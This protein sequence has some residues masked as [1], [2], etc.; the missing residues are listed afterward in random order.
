M[1]ES[2][3]GL[4]KRPFLTVPTLERYCPVAGQ[5]AAFQSCSRAIS[6]SE[7]PV[8]ILGRTGLGKS[9]VCLRIGE[10]FRRS[11]EVILLSSSQLC[12]RRALL[13]NLLFELRMPYRDLSEG[14]LRLSLLDRLQPSNENPTDGVVLIVD[15][16]QT[17]SIK[18]LEEL[19]L[20]TNL[21]RDG[22][23]RVRLVLCGSMR[24]EE[25]LGHPQLESLNQRIACRSY[26]IPLSQSETLS[27]LT[28]KVELCGATIGS[29]FTDDAM[30][31][32]HRAT[33]GVPRLID[34]IADQS[35]CLASESRQRPISAS[36]IES[37]WAS[38]Q[39]LPLPWSDEGIP[40]EHHA[41][42][43]IEYGALNDDNDSEFA[44]EDSVATDS[45]EQSIANIDST[46]APTSAWVYQSETQERPIVSP[47]PSAG[48][49]LSRVIPSVSQSSIPEPSKSASDLWNAFINANEGRFTIEP[50]EDYVDDLL[51]NSQESPILP[52]TF[53]PTPVATGSEY[54]W[55]SKQPFL[56][57]PAASDEL[58]S[59]DTEQESVIATDLFGSDF[60]DEIDVNATETS[61]T[62]VLEND[63]ALVHGLSFEY[64]SFVVPIQD[65]S[66][67]SENSLN[68]HDD[69][70]LLPYTELLDSL[71]SA[72][73]GA[74]TLDMSESL[75]SDALA[76]ES[77]RNV[78]D[79]HPVTNEFEGG[80]ARQTR[81]SILSFADIQQDQKSH[82]SD[83]RDLL[84][85]E[86]DVP[87]TGLESSL[88]AQSPAKVHPYKQLFSKLRG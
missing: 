2:F 21:A 82:M 20:I 24:L 59:Y 31:L 9:M 65:F 52:T 41:E 47:V 78:A 28:H 8:V 73:L 1:H 72:N 58:V 4:Q 7:G 17:L 25:M 71:S 83:D 76:F 55:D 19:R 11:F 12:S 69:P 86:D 35:L 34:Q 18:L 48:M 29:V 15:E 53:E 40:I 46:S 16:A 63:T 64:N 42:A 67:D 54:V 50:I 79:E 62:R 3:F 43:T 57:E 27:Y 39:Q 61:P 5:E 68:P 30:R 45:T 80:L 32:I 77:Y 66:F 6:R 37:A 56:E 81:N 85:I 33:D 23:P 70:S 26:L 75:A 74:M 44:T 22:V 13:Q 88:E 14:E 51:D 87:A 38:L 84:I 10:V 36:L 60:D 49:G